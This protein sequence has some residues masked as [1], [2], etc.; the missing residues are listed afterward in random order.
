MP[1]ADAVKIHV[2][3]EVPLESE[4]LLLLITFGL[5]SLPAPELVAVVHPESCA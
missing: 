5:A 4:L 1:A 3:A 2:K